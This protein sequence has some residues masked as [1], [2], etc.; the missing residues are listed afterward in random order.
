MFNQRFKELVGG[1]FFTVKFVKKDGTDRIMT[2]RRGVKK[3][4]NGRP[5]TDDPNK[6]IVGWEPAT[7]QYRN[8]NIET[9]Q[10]VKCRCMEIDLAA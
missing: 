5:Q 10:W 6:Y 7:K 3:Y 4:S 2:C 9:L 8:I 1:Q